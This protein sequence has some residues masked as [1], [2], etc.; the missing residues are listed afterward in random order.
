MT[1]GGAVVTK[2]PWPSAARHWQPR[3]PTSHTLETDREMIVDDH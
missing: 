3:K 2:R 1:N